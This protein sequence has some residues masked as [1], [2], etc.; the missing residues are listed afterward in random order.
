MTEPAKQPAKIRWAPR[1]RPELLKRLYESDAKGLQD[2]ALC[3]EVGIDLFERC[4]TFYLT[5]RSEV[6]CPVYEREQLGAGATFTGPALV[7]E[8][9]TTTVMF[10]GDVCTV[11]E[12]GELI[13]KVRGE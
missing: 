9:G 12:T 2:L 6:E 5:T 1:L 11:A 8:D 4:R 7:Q 10:E 13:I 3:D